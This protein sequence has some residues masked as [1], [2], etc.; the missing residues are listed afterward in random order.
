[1]EISKATVVDAKAISELIIPLVTKY[2]L[3]TCTGDGPKILLESM[4]VRSITGYIESSYCYLKAVEQGA[5]IAVIGFRDNS[6]LYH[7]FVKEEYQ[8]MGLATQ[9]WELIKDECIAN[10]NS[11]IFTVNAA[12]N[13]VQLYRKI[14][15]KDHSGIR[16]RCGIKD[17]PMRLVIAN[18]IA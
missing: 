12:V 14:G 18:T 13:A 1:M 2:I 4:N 17:I 3:P 16:E 11:G 9:L 5:L 7:L 6:H 8:G 15:F 10:G